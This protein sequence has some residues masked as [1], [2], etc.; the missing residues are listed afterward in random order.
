MEL[1]DEIKLLQSWV[2]SL[3]N[4]NTA[5]FTDY[6]EY[7]RKIVIFMRFCKLKNILN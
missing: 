1:D 2:N 6:K 4:S 7:N 3:P 5:D